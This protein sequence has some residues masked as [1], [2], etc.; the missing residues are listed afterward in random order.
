MFNEDSI[1]IFASRDSIRDQ[2][3]EYAKEYLDLS[4]FDWEK[5]SYLSYLID[6]LSGLTANLLFYSTSTYRE[7]FLTQAVQKE[8][9]LNLAAMLGYSPEFAT[10]ATCQVL[11]EFPTTF[12]S[13][14]IVNI[15]AGFQYLSDSNI[16]FS[17]DNPIVIEINRNP[18]GGIFPPV[19]LEQTSISG[20][21]KLKTNL[22]EDD[23]YLYFIVNTTQKESIYSE[24]KI[25]SLKAFQ[26]HRLDVNFSGQIAGVDLIT[27]QPQNEESLESYI[28][29]IER[30]QYPDES[31]G[32]YTV[33]KNYESLFLIP[34]ETAGYTFRTTRDGGQIFFGNNIVG[35]QPDGGNICRVAIS[36]TKGAQGNVIAGSVTK[37]D[38]LFVEDYDETRDRSVRRPIK[39]RVI[40]T[41]PAIGGLDSPTTDEIRSSAI[42]NV[43][44][45]KRL[46]SWYDF[47]NI[48]D[49]I[50]EL[51][52]EHA[53]S[54][55]KRSDLKINE[56]TVFTDIIFDDYI[57]PT[58]NA[59]WEFDTSAGSSDSTSNLRTIYTSD[60]IQIDGINY[61]S[62]FNIE[63]DVIDKECTYYYYL[64]TVEK[65]ITSTWT[66]QDIDVRSL[67][68]GA[69]FYT[70]IVKDS[71]LVSLEVVFYYD[72]I[73]DSTAT[74]TCELITDW[75]GR[76]YDLIAYTDPDTGGLGF[77]T[78]EGSILLSDVPSGQ[79]V[80]RFKMYQ[81]DTDELGVSSMVE[82]NNSQ[83]EVIVKQ[84]LDDFM[85]S[86]T[87][88]TDSTAGE[89]SVT[90]YDVPV[91]KKSYYDAIDQN[92]FTLQVY[93]RIISLPIN[94]YKMTGSFINLK[95]ADT[96]GL[97]TNMK[98]NNITKDPCIA[99][100]PETIPT[101]P[102][103]GD[104]YV[105]TGENPWDVE[106]P[107]IV[108]YSSAT[109][110]W[111][112]EKLSVNDIIYIDQYSRNLLFN[113]DDMV[114]PATLIPFEI[115]LVVWKDRTY[116][117]SE[118][119]LVQTVKDTL[120]NQLYTKFGFDA[121][122]FLSEIVSTI[123]GVAGVE[124]CK[125]LEPKHDIFFTY[126]IYDD[127]SH[128]ELLEYTPQFIS[129]ITSS[130]NVEI[131]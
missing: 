115:D 99:V 123:Q 81:E 116:S 20:N 24:H 26:F 25:P 8:S 70:D 3:I 79:Q 33:W 10:P 42:T 118:Y 120:V 91:I 47:Y 9:V 43:S 108:V 100:D 127:L 106:Y 31:E 92:S 35:M 59:K 109:S 12:S 34:S 110:A 78:T 5:S 66:T 107:C 37:A 49:I 61:Y 64:D 76:S 68:S 14:V 102:S 83:C 85:Y 38:R 93:D 4:N 90:L 96:T 103:N 18:A 113:G 112:R 67:P 131:R 73:S 41:S 97:M 11:V 65:A 72:E 22:S 51:P 80:Y 126:D 87:H 95:F 57:V 125:V 75:N 117:A 119:A 82:I 71:E 28:K 45:N 77:I 19:V 6:V 84:E 101:S 7:F 46:V 98:Y 13:D 16:K 17:Q 63:V 29:M 52:V 122:I 111:R 40:N 58:R 50:P 89:V 23:Q 129:F 94:R 15:P 21:R 53:T 130:I 1:R 27:T 105:L 55:V 124:H 44:S 2:I 88:V 74:I 128:S 54:V 32:L 104:R 56:T 39:M 30:G 48:K 62:M 69:R 114:Y 121:G 36:S 60:T 86:Q